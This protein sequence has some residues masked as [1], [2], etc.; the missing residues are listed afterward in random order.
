MSVGEV[1]DPFVAKPPRFK[2]PRITW[3]TVI[4]LPIISFSLV[5]ICMGI[6]LIAGSPYG[7]YDVCHFLPNI[8][9][10]IIIFSWF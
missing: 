1:T 6:D 7:A 4:L 8:M 9:T 2:M 3:A 5:F 10:K